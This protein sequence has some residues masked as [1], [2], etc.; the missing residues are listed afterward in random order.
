MDIKTKFSRCL[1]TVN[2]EMISIEKDELLSVSRMVE[3]DDIRLK[4]MFY[5]RRDEAVQVPCSGDF[6]N[7][8]D[9]ASFDCQGDYF[10]LRV[11]KTCN[12]ISEYGNII[13]KRILDTEFA[14][15][16]R[17]KTSDE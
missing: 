6:P 10:L 13:K 8:E 17:Y 2:C 1:A 14:I 4:M 12:L 16:S 3:N 7:D 15:I 11:S 9:F 5:K